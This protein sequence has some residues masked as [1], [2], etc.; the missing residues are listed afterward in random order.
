MSS[1]T[2]SFAQRA[3]NTKFF[4]AAADIS[5][6]VVDGLYS[7]IADDE[8]VTSAGVAV[9]DLSGSTLAPTAVTIGSGRLLKDLGR[10]ITIVDYDN[11]LTTSVYRQIQ[12]VDGAATEGVGGNPDV[13]TTASVYGCSYVKVYSAD[14]L[15][16][17]VYR[18]G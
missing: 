13:G 14:G 6:F 7:V 2:S 12:L 9:P 17:K 8:L 3:K 5:G 1:V 10:Q 15:G 4:V 16:V 11:N 18:T